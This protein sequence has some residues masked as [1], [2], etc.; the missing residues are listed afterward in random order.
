MVQR[1]P[2]WAELYGLVDHGRGHWQSAFATLDDDERVSLTPMLADMATLDA[3]ESRDYRR[4]VAV[5]EIAA[6]GGV[7]GPLQRRSHDI[8]GALGRALELSS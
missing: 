7:E 2:V 1:H 8:L 3:M 5:L 4:A 6:R